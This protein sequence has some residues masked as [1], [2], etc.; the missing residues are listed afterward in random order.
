MEWTLGT[1]MFYIG[2]IGTVTT[3]IAAVITVIILKK[4]KKEITAKLNEEYGGN[5]K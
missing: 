5:L 1:L 3:I 4:S 2:I